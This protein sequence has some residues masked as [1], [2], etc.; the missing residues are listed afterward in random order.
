MN[1]TVHVVGF[2]GSLRRA[3]YNRAALRAAAEVLPAGMSLE[4]VDLAMIPLYNADLEAA[5]LPQPVAD[6][7]ARLAAADALFIVTPEYNYSVPGVLKNAIDW[8]SRTPEN[9]PLNRKP[10]AIM[11]AGG[12]FGTL[13][14]QQHLRQLLLHNNV[15]VLGKPEV[16]ITDACE[17]FDA[18]GRLID[19]RSRERIRSLLLALRDWVWLLD[20]RTAP[21]QAAAS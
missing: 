15:L 21:A 19:D 16:Y 6:F 7:K 3:S 17:K 4:T 1:A 2:A 13:R 5:G 14:A 12:P 10:A 20:G 18:A 11:G 9:S 8:A